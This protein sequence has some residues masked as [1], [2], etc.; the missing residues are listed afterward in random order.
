MLRLQLAHAPTGAEETG[1]LRGE[2]K[3]GS[4]A[5]RGEM[6]HVKSENLRQFTAF[7]AVLD[8]DVAETSRQRVATIAG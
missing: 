4:D 1:P 6:N 5:A 2:V 8:Y 7:K 3:T